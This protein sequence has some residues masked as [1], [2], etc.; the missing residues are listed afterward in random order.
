MV[1]TFG[2]CYILQ[3]SIISKIKTGFSIDYIGNNNKEKIHG[4]RN[5]HSK[6]IKK[7]G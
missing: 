3:G 1:D 4:Q 7:Y 2:Q 6:A 5:N